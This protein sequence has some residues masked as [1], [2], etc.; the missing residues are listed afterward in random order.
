MRQE[1]IVRFGKPELVGILTEASPPEQS[2]KI[3]LL[4]LNAGMLSRVGPNRL[5]VRLAR[6]AQ[7]L[8]VTSLRFDFSGIGE[9][10]ATHANLE[11]EQFTLKE[12]LMAADFLREDGSS[13]LVV[14]G[15]CSGAE[16]ALRLLL[17]DPRV[18]HA[19]LVNPRFVDVR[20][21][22]K[23]WDLAN[24]RIA[25]KHILRRLLEA[26]AWRNVLRGQSKL[27]RDGLLIGAKP[28]GACSPTSQ[29]PQVSQALDP[30]PAM[31]R[32]QSLRLVLSDLD[33]HVNLYHQIVAPRLRSAGLHPK[34]TQLQR[35]DHVLTLKHHQDQMIE[36]VLQDLRAL[37]FVAMPS[38]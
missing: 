20:S 8:G 2:S 6:A 22:P 24:R 17:D 10:P 36:A 1:C 18:N 15:M 25:R 21:V 12:A 14:C 23:Q 35:A 26:D 13:H 37:Q 33:P 34:V 30:A 9:S 27:S 4:L 31:Q 19:V 29:E 3:S 38:P 7:A 32:G 11:A 5:Y 28:Q 16:V